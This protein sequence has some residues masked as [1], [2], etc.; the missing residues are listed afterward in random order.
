[1][2]PTRFFPGINKELKIAAEI[3]ALMPMPGTTASAYLRKECR[4]LKSLDIPIQN[5]GG[6][7]MGGAPSI[8]RK[9]SGMSSF[10]LKQIKNTTVYNFITSHCSIQQY[11]LRAKLLKVTNTVT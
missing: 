1:M 2:Q 8:A 9:N 4:S 5:L 6:I 7:V 10:I 11:S 3:T